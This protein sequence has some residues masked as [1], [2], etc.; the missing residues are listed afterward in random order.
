ML[1]ATLRKTMAERGWHGVAGYCRVLYLY[2]FR[3]WFWPLCAEHFPAGLCPFFRRLQGVRVG[4]NVFI[5]RSVIL[6]GVHPELIAI[7]ND[8]RLA[9]GAV[10]CCHVR[11]G[12]LLSEKYMPDLVAP[13]KIGESAFIGIN[14]VILPGVTIGKG[15]VVVS[16]S[17]VYAAVPDFCVVSGNPARIIKH[18]PAAG[19]PD[20]GNNTDGD[21][22]PP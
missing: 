5:D 19:Q 13:V 14:A 16:G 10:V 9:P 17:V 8:A 12:K 4:K 18:F 7:G 1:A 3:A 20:A 6:D 21:G 15:A 11:A 2:C 22:A